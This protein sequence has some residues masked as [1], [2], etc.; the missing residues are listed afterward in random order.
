MLAS[1]K[2]EREG[3]EN[4]LNAMSQKSQLDK[5]IAAASASTRD[6]AALLSSG[7]SSSFNTNNA[8]K[9]TPSSGR[10]LGK[11]TSKTRALDNQGVLQLQQQMMQEQDAD[12]MVLAQAVSRQKE[13]GVAIQEELEVG[14]KLLE[15]LGE[16]V[17]RVQGK[18]DVARKRVDK[19]S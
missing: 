2:R 4:L 5:T 12:V 1:A 15:M 17:D 10:V 14:D 9:P 8:T 18:M 16:D 3:L 19:I 7:A 6:K 13:L 11:E